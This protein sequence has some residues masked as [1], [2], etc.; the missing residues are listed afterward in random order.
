MPEAT[1][2][3]SSI[4]QPVEFTGL[5][6][7]A[8][9]HGSPDL[10]AILKREYLDFRVDEQLGFEFS[11]QGEHLCIRVK[12]TDHSTV[13]VVKRL[14]E[15]TGVHRSAIGYAGMKD[16]RAETKQW[17]SL[18][19]AA[20]KEVTLN[21][22]ENESLQ[23]LERHRNS[24]KIKIG[25]HKSNHFQIRLRNCQGPQADFE[26]RLNTIKTAGVPNYFGSQRFGH[27]L[28]NLTQVQTLMQSELGI[29]PAIGGRS[30]MPKQRF[31]RGMLF[32]AARSYLFNQLLSNRLQQGSWNKYRSGDVLNLDGTDRCFLLK[33][34]SDW[35]QLLQQRLDG[36]DIHITGLLPGLQDSKDKYVS[37]GEAA[38]IEDA[39]YGQFGVLMAGLR[40]FG[41][42]ASRRS[43]RFRPVDL[44][45][46]W[47]Q[48][49]PRLPEDTRPTQAS[50]D[51]L[52]DFSL[53]KGAYATSLL[54]ELCVT[55]EPRQ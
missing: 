6:S 34:E 1:A 10:G 50:Q 49:D 19:L 11:E 20:D 32:S 37:S 39:V 24:R 15:V 30:V 53:V 14:S 21:Q 33:S 52:L 38:D 25:S 2:A 46:Q 5:D 55:A 9:A 44:S 45:W 4:L 36:F 17:F 7:L 22:F 3:Q 51:L 47:M 35:D 12:K 26:A 29:E 48:S 40:H 27:N 42:Q 8:F 28:T 16:R 18:Q 31:K 54:R 41:L 13:D 23:I 43:F